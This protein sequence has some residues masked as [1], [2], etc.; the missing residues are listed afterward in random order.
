MMHGTTYQATFCRKYK[1]VFLT[2][3]VQ[4]LKKKGAI[5]NIECSTLFL[6]FCAF[7]VYFC[8]PDVLKFTITIINMEIQCFLIR[9]FTRF[10]K[11][12]FCPNCLRLL[13]SSVCLVC[14]RTIEWL[15]N[16]NRHRSR[17]NATLPHCKR[18][19]KETKIIMTLSA[20]LLQRDLI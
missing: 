15:K 1:T 17:V 9:T 5:Q 18:P 13:H 14:I 3:L 12:T 6:L 11:L 7:Y 10:F 20:L 4:F 8:K 2:E 19:F 16:K